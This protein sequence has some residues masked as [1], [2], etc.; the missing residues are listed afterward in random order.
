M[1]IKTDGFG[2]KTMRLHSAKDLR[3]EGFLNAARWFGNTEK[4]WND[5][6]TEKNEEQT[7]TAYLNWNNK[8]LDQNLNDKYLVLYNSSAKDAN[9]T[10]VKRDEIDFEF[11]ADHKTYLFTSSNLNEAYYL[12]AILNSTAPNE[13]M[14]DY[15]SRGLYGARDIH[16]KIL[17]IY[18]PRFDKSDVTHLHLAELSKAAHAKASAF[19]AS[20]PPQHDL[21]P[22]RLGRLRLDIKKH[23]TNEMRDIDALVEQLIG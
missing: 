15:Q 10:V 23:L 4:A 14:K 11:I 16:K 22:M 1:T 3:N 7:A 20:N 8:I 12:T 9:A 13:M 6:R 2:L 21:T 17:D 19:L 5:N 18:Y